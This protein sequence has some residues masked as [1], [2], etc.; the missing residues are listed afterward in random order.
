M[1][2]NKEYFIK[3]Y[4]ICYSSNNKIKWLKFLRDNK[5]DLEHIK[6]NN[7]LISA[8]EFMDNNWYMD[9]GERMWSILKSEK[10]EKLTLDKLR[11]EFINLYNE[12]ENSNLKE[13]FQNLCLIHLEES[14]TI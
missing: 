2:I 3:E 10:Y 5:G 4:R 8:K 12:A 6:Y 7:D 13:E 1:N 9:G 11:E 14:Q